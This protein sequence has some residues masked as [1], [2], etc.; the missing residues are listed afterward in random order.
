LQGARLHGP[1]AP[2]EP[3]LP[4]D[5]HTQRPRL[6]LVDDEPDILDFLE[7]ALRRRYQVRRC[8]SASEA[9]GE[10]E[11]CSADVLLTDQMMPQLTGLELLTQVAERWPDTVRVLI[12]GFTEVRLL[13]DALAVSRIHNF[14]L[15]PVD[16]RRLLE[17]LDAATARARY[18]E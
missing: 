13:A 7:R 10:L 6:L 16:S 9:L 4:T 15:K 8:S 17:A 2:G 12:S 18:D 3:E 1:I 11:R 14:V 5:A